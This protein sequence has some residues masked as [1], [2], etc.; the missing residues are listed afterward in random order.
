MANIDTKR[1]ERRLVLPKGQLR[2]FIRDLRKILKPVSFSKNNYSQTIYLNTEDLRVPWG[3]SIRARRYVKRPDKNITIDYL[4][5]YIC[6]FKEGG[7]GS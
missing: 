3:I 2:S 5:D 1:F 7:F 4:N 6:E